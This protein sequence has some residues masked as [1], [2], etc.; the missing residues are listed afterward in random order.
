MEYSSQGIKLSV[1]DVKTGG[2][3][4]K[5]YGLYKV[6]DMGGDTEKLDVTNFADVNKRSIDSGLS[7]YGSPVFDFYYNKEDEEDSEQDETALVLNT[8]KYLKSCQIAA[9][10]LW[11]KLEYPD[12]TGH[13]WRGSVSVKRNSVGIAEALKFQL[14]TTVSSEMEEI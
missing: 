11:F 3:F 9:K 7:D 2:T 6:P 10:S 14:T 13:L 4:K 1:S 8:Y 12:G 5:L